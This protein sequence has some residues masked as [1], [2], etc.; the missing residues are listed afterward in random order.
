MNIHHVPSNI[1]TELQQ[2]N[3]GLDQKKTIKKSSHEIWHFKRRARTEI[4][5]FFKSV[6]RIKYSIT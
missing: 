6:D 1:Q 2:L 5:G 4:Y 3:Q